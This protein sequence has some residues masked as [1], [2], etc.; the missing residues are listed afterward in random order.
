MQLEL[1]WS[2][3][4][5]CGEPCNTWFV[6]HD[7]FSTLEMVFFLFK[8]VLVLYYLTLKMITVIIVF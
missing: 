7:I 8:K 3:L 4:V 6:L 5:D 1:G 2:Q